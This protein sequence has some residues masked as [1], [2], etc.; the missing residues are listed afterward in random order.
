M[1]DVK[2][3]VICNTFNHEKY[4]R[5]AIEGFLIQ[6]TDFPFEV[7]IHDDASTDGT[8]DVIREYEKKYPNIIKPIYQKENKYSKGEDISFKYQIPRVKGKYIAICEGDDYWSDSF[9]LQK[10]YEAMEK[11]P[12]ID[13]CAHAAKKISAN[14]GDV[15]CD[16]KPSERDCIFDMGKVILGGGGFVATNTLFYRK[17]LNNNIPKFRRFCHLDYTIQMHGSIRGGMLYLVDNMSVYRA[18]VPGSWTYRMKNKDLYRKHIEKIL[19]MFDLLNVET[20]G[21]YSEIIKQCK[22]EIAFSEYEIIGDLLHIRTGE[23]KKIYDAKPLFWKLKFYIKENLP[24]IVN[25]YR[26]LK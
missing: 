21:R 25:M 19:K 3:S 10:Q 26:K 20:A 22:L 23:L 18:S 1:N 7:L 4:I 24:F 6:K 8:A 12:E 13:I 16:I 14:K 15:I 2:V 17:E 9:K 11:H 5:D